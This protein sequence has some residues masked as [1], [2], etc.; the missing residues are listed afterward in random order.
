VTGDDYDLG[1]L[2][3]AGRELMT[4]ADGIVAALDR[5]RTVLS[6]QGA[7]WGRD[8]LG[9][10]FGASYVEFVGQAVPAI[11]TYRD[12]VAYAGGEQPEVAECFLDLERLHSDQL[13]QLGIA[14]GAPPVAR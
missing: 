11:D 1:S 7:P 12:Q 2:D 13:Q 10:R 6:D 9:A 3:R 4:E 14:L 5:L 8:D